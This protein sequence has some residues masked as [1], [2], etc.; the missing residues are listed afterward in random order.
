MHRAHTAFNLV[1]SPIAQKNFATW[2]IKDGN[3]KVWKN[4]TVLATLRA[5]SSAPA[6][7][8]ASGTSATYVEEM[9]NSW[10]RDPTS[11][12]TSW[13]AYFRS[14]S[15]NAPPDFQPVQRNLIPLSG[16]AT[17]LSSG[18]AIDSKTIED[19]LA[20]QAIIRSYQSR[21]HLAA[22]LDPLGILRTDI[23]V[24]KDGQTRRA[25]EAVLRQH[26]S[27][28]V[29]EQ[30]M[31]RPFKL[32]ST[33]FI[34]GDETT[35]PLREILNRL[36]NVYCNKVGVEYMF[37]NSLEQCNWI[38]KRFETPGVMN[39]SPEQKRL[40]L[41][42]LTRATGFEAFLAKKYSS[43]KRFGL[44][45]GE[46]LIPAMKEVIDVSTELGVESVIMG[47]P[48]RGRL[49]V[50]A[51]VCRK[52]LPQIFTQ[53]AGLEAADDGSGDVKYHLGTYIE[54]LN[55]V[56]NK[57]IR[58]AVVANPSHL[59]ASCPVVQ[60]KTRAEQFYR[61]DQEGKKVMS[62]LLHGD[63]A[64]CGQGVVYE[65][66][67]LS[68]LPDYTTHGTIHVVVNN[69]IGFTTDPR[70]SRSSPYCTDVA[71]VV[72]APIFHVNA[73][74]PEAVVHV[75]RVAAEWRATFHKDVVIDLVSYRRNGH[76]E[77]DE[78]MFTQPLMYQKIR[79]HKTCLEL[80]ANKLIAEG[81]VTPEEVK[82]VADKYDKI[83]EESLEL[84]KQ[85]THIKYKDWLDSPWSGFFEGK[86]PLKVSPTGVKEETLIHIGNR[87]SAPPPNAAEF[88]IHKGLLRVLA[89]RKNMVDEKIAD[90]A[91]A[92]AMAFGSLLKEGIHVRLSGQDVERGTFSHRHHVLHHQLVDKAVYN[93]L[94]HL[95]PDQAPYSVS[96]SSLSEFA[97]L[98][99]EHGYSM[100]NP[101]ALVLWEAQFGDFCNTAQCIIDQFISSGQAKWVRQSGLVCLLPHGM[102]GMGPEHSSGR[103]ERFLSLCADDPDYFPPESD[104]FA[105]RQLHDINMIVANCSTPANYYHILRRQIAMPFRKP[106]ILM[107]P[108]SLLRH[109]LARS[110]FKEM[111]EGSEFRRVIPDEGPAAENADNVKK[112]LFC[113]GRVF[114]D[115]LKA[116]EDK[117]LEKEIAIVRVEQISPFPFDLVKEQSNVYK[118]AD[119][120]WVQEE[121]KNSGAWTYVQPRFLTALNHDKDVGSSNP[122]T[123]QTSAADSA[124]DSKTKPWLSRV[125]AN[126]KSDTAE[127]DQKPVDYFDARE[128]RDMQGNFN[129]PAGS[130]DISPKYNFGR[131]I[132]YIGRPCSASTATGSKVQHT[133]E[134]NALLNDAT[135]V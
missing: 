56:T 120:F 28:F 21:G 123:I 3:S 82:A 39:Y 29:G 104:E 48:H 42:R 115:L 61:G 128:V 93:P 45:G 30:D 71:R 99:F 124:S 78:P 135:T 105:I 95:Y 49:N 41:A 127:G 38:R 59:E 111:A 107:T 37:I 119:L 8:F 86:D 89:A 67:H 121:H 57:N 87:F 66:M 44:E 4:T 70:F 94:Q 122:A 40:I 106:L 50:L 134:L 36:E 23:A 114:Y 117:K 24:S 73:D 63:A 18:G 35:L 68:D 54:R 85:E 33:T 131:K 27:F 110:P 16:G 113:T 53:F 103:L 25:N 60:G 84:A 26:S 32:P 77:V 125:F 47:M 116:R 75:S 97:V 79:K 90:W 55:R 62:I 31:D 133:R 101:N 58:L 126:E 11:V 100:T 15:Y 46:M 88:V 118:N 65:T 34:G 130:R 74:D 96:N 76:N 92:E 17:A 81:T 52:P 10:L 22:D 13:D 14:N 2:L 132:S 9:Y 51:N 83:C 98:G 129:K 19:H 6:E 43:E 112:V 5:Y 109:P 102:E 1:L 108:K 12:H 7:Q 69:Q 72:N 80:Y 91:L 64:F 20:V